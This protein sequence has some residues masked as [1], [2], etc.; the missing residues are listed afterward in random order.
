MEIFIPTPEEKQLFGIV[1]LYM[2]FNFASS[3]I[4]L[5]KNYEAK[6]RGALSLLFGF[7]LEFAFMRLIGFKISMP[8]K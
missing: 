5:V 7:I 6:I 8:L 3:V 2:I 1:I 4:L